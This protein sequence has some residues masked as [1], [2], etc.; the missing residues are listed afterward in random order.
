MVE[1]VCST[2]NVTVRN[3]FSYG[4]FKGIKGGMI[5]SEIGFPRFLFLLRLGE[6]ERTD[7]KQRQC[8]EALHIRVF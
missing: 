5:D 4:V 3:V 8:E 7:Q 1:H 6:E 2:C